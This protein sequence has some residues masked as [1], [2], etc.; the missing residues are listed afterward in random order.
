MSSQ[1]TP[2]LFIEIEGNDMKNE[3]R[4]DAVEVAVQGLNN[5]KL[6]S[7]LE[8]AKFIKKKFDSKYGETWVCVVGAEF[9]SVVTPMPGH[10][11]LFRVGNMS[12]QLFKL[13]K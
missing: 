2:I 5:Q 11:I 10:Y 12:I 3:M 6:T 1:K 13:K 9:G 4:R 8:V 7:E